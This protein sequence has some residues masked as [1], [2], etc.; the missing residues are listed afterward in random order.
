MAGPGSNH[1]YGEGVCAAWW[2][3]SGRAVIQDL[4]PFGRHELKTGFFAT[5]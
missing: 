3:V 5:F 1:S 4:F 2:I